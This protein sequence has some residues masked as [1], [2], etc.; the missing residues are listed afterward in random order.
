MG[1]LLNRRRYMGGG[2]PYD[3]FGYIKDGKVFHLDGINKGAT[4][5]SW[6]D[7]VGGNVF[8]NNGA[9]SNDTYFY[10][11]NNGYLIGTSHY[12]TIDYTVE[13][14]FAPDAR[15]EGMVFQS[16]ADTLAGTNIVLYQYLNRG[17]FLSKRPIYNLNSVVDN[18]TI[19]LNENI[20]VQNGVTIS[21]SANSDWWSSVDNFLIGLNMYRT[22]S[23]R[24]YYTGKIYSIRFYDRRLTTE[25]ILHNQQV[26]NIRFNLG[27]NI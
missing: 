14:C 1:T 18:N 26:D 8:E 5:G 15:F 19:S 25:E 22:G 24:M 10:F 23:K 16:G 2:S 21:R 20:G 17:L 12:G 3:E 13:T 11:S 4:D 6:V 9:V 7:L 27:L